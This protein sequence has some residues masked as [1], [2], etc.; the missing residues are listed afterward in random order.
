MS[1]TPPRSRRTA[2][3]RSAGCRRGISSAISSRPMPHSRR[4]G[5]RREHVQQVA[6]AEE[7]RLDRPLPDRRLDVGAHAAMPRSRMSRARTVA[8]LGLSEC[9]HPARKSGG[10]R[11]H[12]R[13]VGV[14]HQHGVGVGALEDLGLGIGNGVGG[15][16]ET[17]VRVADIRPHANVWRRNLDEPADLAR[18]IHAQFHHGHV[19]RGPQL[20]QRQ[21]KADV[22]VQVPLVLHHREIV[23]P[24]VPRWPPSS[25]SCPRCP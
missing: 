14:A 21:R 11:H 25:S 5:G 16:K 4:H 1:V 19:G 3:R 12:A 7:R 22:V 2:P 23:W 17:E 20:H 15:R 9:Q 8:P 18:V 24:G 10:P 13:I 6:A